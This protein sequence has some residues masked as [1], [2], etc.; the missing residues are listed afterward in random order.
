MPIID[1]YCGIGP[2]GAR[3]PLL[4]Y[5]AEEYLPLM[6]A[7]GVERALIYGRAVADYGWPPDANTLVVEIARAHPRFIPAFTLFAHAHAR[8]HTVVQY[9]DEMQAAG[10][11][12]A[13]LWPVPGSG[14]LLWVHEEIYARCEELRIPLFIS[15]LRFGPDDLDK[16]CTAFPRLRLVLA[17]AHYTAD[18]WL[19]P[20]FRRH[21]ELR[22]CYGHQYVSSQALERFTH[23]F[24]ARRLLFG[25]GLPDFSPGSMVGMAQYAKL[26]DEEK[27]LILG[28]NLE[29]LLAEVCYA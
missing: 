24:D 27:E 22:L 13:W 21:A 6:D 16:I 18:H 15:A 17:G 14:S 9:L 11:R 8:E 28:G 20:L 7:C 29:T 12:A 3:D 2:W 5:T 10:A 1:A 25:S 26:T 23:E 4:P 19:Y